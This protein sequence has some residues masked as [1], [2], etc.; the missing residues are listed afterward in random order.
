MQLYHFAKGCQYLVEKRSTQRICYLTR[1]EVMAIAQK[2]SHQLILSNKKYVRPPLDYS[3]EEDIF[4]KT[5]EY[6]FS[7][8]PPIT[9]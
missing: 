9:E 5:L 8:Y 2:L 1:R 6:A 4:A 3:I 7:I